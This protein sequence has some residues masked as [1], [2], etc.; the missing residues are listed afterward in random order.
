MINEN[1]LI[2]YNTSALPAAPW[3]VFAPHADDETFGMG[4]SLLLASDQGIETMVVILTDGALG[5]NNSAIVDIRRQ[6]AERALNA[7][8]VKKYY[9]WNLPDRG[10]EVT[11]ELISKIAEIISR[12]QPQSVFFPSPMELHP[13]HRQTAALVWEGLKQAKTFTG[14]AFSY[15]IGTQGQINYLI[16]ISAVVEKKNQVMALYASQQAIN[17]YIPIVQSLDCARTYTLPKNVRAAEGFWKY[18]TLSK[19]LASSTLDNLRPYWQ[20]ADSDKLPLVSIIVRTKNRPAL[21]KEALQSIWEQTYPKIEIIVVND[22]GD[23]VSEVAH[24]FKSAGIAIVLEQFPINRGRSKAANAGLDKASG[25]YIAFLDDDDW[26]ESEHIHNLV[27]AI[28]KHPEIKVVYS[29]VSCVDGDKKPLPVSFGT[30]FDATQL[31]AGNY[32]PIHAAL[33]SRE[34]L[35]LGCRV[36]ESLEVYEDWDFWIQASLFTRFLFIREYSAVYRIYDSAQQSRLGVGANTTA[37]EKASLILFNKWLPRLQ[38]DQLV[39]LMHA[40]QLKRVK[41]EQIAER[42]QQISAQD[43]AISAL[44]QAIAERDQQISAQDRAISALNQ[45]I[46][47]RDKQFI[48]LNQ[49]IATIFASTSWRVT[50]PL[51]SIG[52]LLKRILHLS[53]MLSDIMAHEGGLK[54]TLLKIIADY[55]REGVSGIRQRLE[56]NEAGSSLIQLEEGQLVNRN[57]YA[58]WVRRYD[59]L[60]DAA[61]EQIRTDIDAMPYRPLISVVMPVYEPLVQF[62]DEAIWSVRRQLYSDWELCIADDASKNDAV[63]DLI[64]RHAAEDARIRMIFRTENGHIS[65]ASN[66]ALTLATGEF[67]ALLDHDDLLPEHALFYVAKTILAN[68]DVGLIYS[69]EDKISQSGLRVDP[70]FKSDWNPDLFYSHNMISHLGV[71]RAEIVREIGG[72][73]V[74]YEG[75]QDYDLALRF[76]EKIQPEQIKHIP[77]ILYHWRIHADSTA[78][79]S[80]SKPYA[81]NAG[82]KALQDHFDRSGITANLLLLTDMNSYRV[83][84]ALPENPPLVSLIIPTRNGYTL[85]RTCVES[86]LSKTTYPNF[87]IL[88][89]DNGSDDPVILNYFKELTHRNSSVRIIRDEQ[90]FNYSAL[91]NSAVQLAGGEIIGLINNDIEVITSDWLT[92]MVSLVMQPGVGCVGARLWYPDDTLQHAGVVLGIGGV[93]SHS[94]RK[95]PKG[96]FGYMGRAA[97]R[98]SFSAVTAA[99]LLVKKSVFE[100]VYGLNE[101][102][103]AV[104]FNDV[105]FCLRV[106]EAGFRN[107]WTPFAELYHHESATRG[108][109]DTPEKKIRFMNETLYMQHRWGEFLLN[110]PAYN[111]NLTL[112]FDDFGLAWPPRNSPLSSVAHHE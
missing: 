18:E 32:I 107:I 99:C 96:H 27:Q 43:R 9:F 67:I 46:A 22:G 10:L 64:K 76:I 87:E 4:G 90:P 81:L 98:Q 31:L 42:D 55:R 101:T 54:P 104:T 52:R 77:H 61:R 102:D 30:P 94:H 105:D 37:I 93:A 25:E 36:D 6:E 16:D 106:R 86:I 47:E 111:P 103:L 92:E 7:L 5:G 8:G 19:S 12:T 34:L 14:K 69:D 74:G 28:E 65:R 3:L 110:D 29:G 83:N 23:D 11:D 20:S 35:K 80:S 63:R 17:N 59:T 33:F 66:S 97:L 100:Q 45:A 58:E 70:Y 56:I 109:D 50:S 44:N 91:N 26:L 75:S 41:D 21:L 95:F 79:S 51:R 82:A 72:F 84:Y 40:V 62:L 48:A 60:N 85:V 78:A 68:P 53:H 71:Y 1:D 49:N 24:L 2:P 89:I 13:D 57:N 38:G 73:R 39:K 112:N 15:E 108:Q 88:I